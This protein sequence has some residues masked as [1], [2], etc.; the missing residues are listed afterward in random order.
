[1]DKEKLLELLRCAMVNCDNI[2]KVGTPMVHV[3][4][5]QI[6]CALEIIE[7]EVESDDNKAIDPTAKL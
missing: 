2:P 3:V 1:M 7:G 5:H 4:K 6:I